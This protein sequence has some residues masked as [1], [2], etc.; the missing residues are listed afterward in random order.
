MLGLVINAFLQRLNLRIAVPVVDGPRSLAPLVPCHQ[1]GFL[2]PA[3][4]VPKLSE[5]SLLEVELMRVL[6]QV[7][8]QVGRP[9]VGLVGVLVRHDERLLLAVVLEPGRGLVLVVV[10][11]VD[12]CVVLLEVVGRFPADAVGMVWEG[13]DALVLC[14]RAALVHELHDMSRGH[15]IKLITIQAALST[16][17]LQLFVLDVVFHLRQLH[18]AHV[19]SVNA[20]E[21]VD[22]GDDSEEGEKEGHEV[23]EHLQLLV[24]P[25]LEGEHFLAA[26]D[27][28]L[29]H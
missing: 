7:V 15:S 17:R 8:V 9:I 12:K 21:G 25:G 26:A 23:R 10:S 20:H 14:V 16:S 5:S 13:A 6:V 11:V 4:L 29:M 27:V 19:L 3:V 2:H 18:V 22:D 28:L 1:V 24:L